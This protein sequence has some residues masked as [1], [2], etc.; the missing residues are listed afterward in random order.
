M[1]GT[2]L[3]GRCE[4]DLHISLC[5]NSNEA[6]LGWQ[7]RIPD[8][9]FLVADFLSRFSPCKDAAELLKKSLVYYSFI[10]PFIVDIK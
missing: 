4:F 3:Y 5:P 7:C 2:I 10:H 8:V 9:Y 6:L 1:V